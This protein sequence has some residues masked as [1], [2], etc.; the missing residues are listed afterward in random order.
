MGTSEPPVSTERNVLICHNVEDGLY[1][2]IYS[3]NLKFN[4]HFLSDVDDVSFQKF[5]CAQNGRE[6]NHD[7]IPQMSYPTLSNR[8]LVEKQ[9]ETL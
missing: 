8:P 4:S 6:N 3:I 1:D 2:S 7:V 5:D 9:N